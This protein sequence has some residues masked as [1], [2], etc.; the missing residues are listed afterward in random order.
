MNSIKTT[1]NIKDLENLSGIKA[2]TIRIWEKR[3]KVLEPMRTDTNIRIYDSEALQKLL[4]ISTLNSFGYKISNIA[5]MPQEKVPQLVSEVLS[6]KSMANHVVSSFKLAMMN[7]DTALFLNT[8]NSLLRENT[9]TDIFYNYFLPLLREVGDLWQ[10]GTITPAHEHF[11]SF[12]IKQKIIANIEMVQSK[13]PYK[14]EKTYVLY[15]PVNE[16]HELG[17]M[18][19]NYELLSKGYR[20]VYLGESVPVSCL[21]RL[22]RFFDDITFVTHITVEP[23]MA[24]INNYIRQMKEEVLGE[25]KSELYVLGR[26]TQFMDVEETGSRVTVFSDIKALSATL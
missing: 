22:H 23:Q 3:Y 11:I 20:T 8:Y 10:T 19:I 18:F 2:H 24:E 4:N 13:E 15:L 14:T 26:N 5:K 6:K 1:F 21:T 7:F 25:G 16:I 12:L 17:L 9:F